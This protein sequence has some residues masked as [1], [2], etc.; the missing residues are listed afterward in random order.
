MDGEADDSEKILGMVAWQFGVVCAGILLV[1][2][3]ALIFVFRKSCRKARGIP[4]HQANP[5]LVNHDAGKNDRGD[6]VF[7]LSESQPNDSLAP[8]ASL[9]PSAVG[10][11]RRKKKRKTFA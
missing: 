4:T 6:D 5:E 3:A 11:K 1:C 10:L 9:A 2:I 7:D 8:M